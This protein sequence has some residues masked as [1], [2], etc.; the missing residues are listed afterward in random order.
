MHQVLGAH[1]V[2]AVVVRMHAHGVRH[3]DGLGGGQCRAGHA[4]GTAP[5]QA[6]AAAQL[7]EQGHQHLDDVGIRLDLQAE[8]GIE[9]TQLG[10]HHADF[11]L[12]PRNRADGLEAQPAL[13]RR[14]HAVDAL[15][16]VVAGGDQVEAR[17]GIEDAVLTGQF[18]DQDDA[19][20]QHRQQRILQ[21]QRAA[22]QLLEAQQLTGL[23]G[24]VQGPR[25][26]RLGTGAMLRQHPGIPAVEHLL[27]A[28][29]GV[30]LNGQGRVAAD[31]RRQQL[32]QP[33]LGRARLTGEQA[34]A[35]GAQGNDG[36]S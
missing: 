26:Q 24:P 19:L 3:V 29:N 30:A 4:V 16:D 11:I 34:A 9:L 25:H 8:I 12:D 20:G 5:V 31:G 15:V 13:E 32:R 33:G 27:Q 14:T 22:C 35:V 21:R 10:L 36:A 6:L 2:V 1:L 28:G 17:P 18:G 7:V 23:H